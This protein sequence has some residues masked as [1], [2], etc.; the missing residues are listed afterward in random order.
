MTQPASTRTDADLPHLVGIVL[1]RLPLFL[2][3]FGGLLLRFK[4]Q[5]QRGGRIFHRELLNQ[6]LDIQTAQALTEH[7]LES[8]SLRNYLF[9]LR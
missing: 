6:G 8:S 9:A 2:V 7:Y 5:A 4:G 3:R 1:L